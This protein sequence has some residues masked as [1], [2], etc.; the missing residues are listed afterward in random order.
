MK[1][2]FLPNINE[3][4]K[5]HGLCGTDLPERN[6]G[7]EWRRLRNFILKK[8]KKEKNFLLT[9]FYELGH[10]LTSVR[11]K[12]TLEKTHEVCSSLAIWEKCMK[13]KKITNEQ[14][15]WA[16]KFD[17]QKHDS[18]EVIFKLVMHFKQFM[19]IQYLQTSIQLL[20]G[21]AKHLSMV[22]NLRICIP[23]ENIYS[24]MYS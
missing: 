3:K 8:K 14:S 22:F 15:R 18:K 12:Q 7:K 20:R 1:F 2:V 23:T 24:S 6:R 5:F 11:T 16:V 9:L 17:S 13:K 10:L 21:P 4:P 19:Y